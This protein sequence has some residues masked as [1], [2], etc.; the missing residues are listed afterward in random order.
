MAMSRAISKTTRKK[1]RKSMTKFTDEQQK[2]LEDIVSFK[3]D[4]FDIKHVSGNV[5]GNVMGHV[6][7][8]VEGGIWGSVF[9]GVKGD[10]GGNI[11][12]HVEGDVWGNVW[13]NVR[14]NVRGN[15]WGNVKGH[16]GDSVE[17]NNKKES[18]NM[19][20]LTFEG[21]QIAAGETAIYDE[22]LEIMYPALGLAGEVGEV[23]NKIKKHYRDGTDLDTEDLK[24][25]LG[26][27][28]WYLG[29]LA[30]DLDID[31]ADAAEGNLSKLASRMERGVLQG[32]GDNR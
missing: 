26:D 21:Y 4:T 29:A 2:F 19:K 16:V 28:L 27:I 12:G 7:N 20:Y 18:E 13:G 1:V 11:E 15:V 23:L 10:V 31:L 9:E 22:K 24:K 25:E 3:G 6:F 32:N 8:D 14:G 17:M 30:T 5:L